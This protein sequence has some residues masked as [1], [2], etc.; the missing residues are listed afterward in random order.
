MVF[1]AF[2]CRLFS[3]KIQS[4][5]RISQKYVHIAFIVNLTQLGI[6][7]FVIVQN[8]FQ[9]LELIFFDPILIFR[10]IF[11]YLFFQFIVFLLNLM[12]S[13]VDKL[14]IMSYLFYLLIFFFIFELFFSFS[15]ELE[16]THRIDNEFK[17]WVVIIFCILALWIKLFHIFFVY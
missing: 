16:T 9:V 17:F 6:E 1:Q 12:F 4:L 15:Y 7:K 3:I 11:L 13:L 2:P 14:Q 5:I 10:F 8:S